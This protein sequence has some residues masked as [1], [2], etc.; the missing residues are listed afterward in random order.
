MKLE[1]LT[2]IAGLFFVCT[3]YVQA[4]TVYTPDGTYTCTV[5]DL[6]L[7]H[8]SEPRDLSTSRMPSSA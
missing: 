8:I 5:Y 6:S 7:I 1:T 3:M 4:E 2:L